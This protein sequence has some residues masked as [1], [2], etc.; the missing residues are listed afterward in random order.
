MLEELN[1][2]LEILRQNPILLGLIFSIV[3]NIGGYIVECFNAKKLVPYE[4]MKLLETL[5]LYETFFIALGGI[6]N[7]PATWTAIVAVAVDMLRSIK[8]AVTPT[9]LK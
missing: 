5:T 1:A 9:P 4:A 6:A 7:L 8:K 2:I 3:R